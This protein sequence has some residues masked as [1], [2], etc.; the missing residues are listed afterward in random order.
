MKKTLF[1]FAALAAATGV[2]A[3]GW[4]KPVYSG[5]FQ[6]LTPGD[7][8][9]VF[10]TES[11]QFL[12]EGND[13]GTHATMSDMGMLVTVQKYQSQ[14]ED[15]TLNDWDGKTY[16]IRDFS[17][18]KAG[19]K[20]LFI[21]A[22]GLY[23]DRGSQP[24]YFF[25]FI[26]KGNN[27]YNIYGADINP[28]YNAI[29][30]MEGYLVGQDINY[31]NKDNGE[32]T[33]TGVIYE[34]CGVDSE[35]KEGEYH[36]TWAFVS[37][38][39]YAAFL[40]KQE[41]YDAAVAL[42]D[43]ISSAE[44]AGLDVSAEKAVY[45]NTNSTKEQLDEAFNSLNAKMLEYYE[46]TVTPDNPID[47]THMIEDP[48][49]DTTD[50]WENAIGASTWEN[51]NMS[52][53]WQTDWEEGAFADSYLNI[54]GANL[55][56][57]VSQK[58]DGLPKGIYVITLGALAEKEGASVFANENSKQIPADSKGH[59][60][61]ITTN[62]TSGNLEFGLVQ[63]EEGT[64]WLCM[65]N[66]TIKYYGAGL[67]AYKFWLKELK[68]TATDLSEAKISNDL[69]KKYNEILDRV[70]AA[71]TE[72]KILAVV[73]DYENILAEVSLNVLAYT[74]LS[75][76]ID[77]AGALQ[78]QTNQYYGEK[79]SDFCLETASPVIE[80]HELGTLEIANIIAELDALKNEAQQY[81]WNMEKLNDEVVKA[82][83]IYNEYSE[84]CKKDA[85]DAYLTFMDN[86]KS[87]DSSTLTNADVEKMLNDLYDI[88][89]NLQLADE[90]ASDEN[91]V[92]YT[93]KI[94]NPTF[95]GVDGWTNEGWATFSNNTWYGFANEEGASS[96]DGDYLNLW[97]TSNARGYQKVENLPAGAYTVQLGAYADN[98]GL[99]VYA[100]DN[101]VDI[102]VGRNDGGEYMRIYT[103]D[104]IV[105]EDGVLEIGVENTNGGTQWAMID[106]VQLLYKG[107]E[108]NII[109]C[110]S[111]IENSS[112]AATSIYSINGVKQNSLTK[113]LNIVKSADGS[114]KK[115]LVK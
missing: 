68:E 4:E 49:F 43:I 19:W 36:T 67:D 20:D 16:I 108:S 14:N 100:N 81:V 114:I 93:A 2:F 62:V 102:E 57:L 75:I 23:V 71:D 78:E 7:T 40:I 34:Y 39:D 109:T 17:V 64:N 13:W 41:T 87:L 60:Y 92:D 26:D 29:G 42:G 94:Y 111:K 48:T 59:L 101:K 12:T 1:L 35:F 27:T 73:K 56:G 90:V 79:L 55:D 5:N 63:N 10:N 61:T 25:S 84:T 31:V 51:A 21:N 8:V 32:V 105:G 37:Q 70:E 85:K 53:G 44:A 74:A 95:I 115:I 65:D 58:F 28:T 46:K 107:T 18:V 104:A 76:A 96:G 89:F 77:E 106:E 54:W 3:E 91:P 50:G 47:L 9:Y 83:V 45:N 11:K 113:G 52:A 99:Q 22:D 30:E 110:I 80:A 86:Y 33:G 38:E 82:E 69:I 24:D 66:A 72:E 98:E 103:I 6:P 97:N 112:K 88:E 15:E